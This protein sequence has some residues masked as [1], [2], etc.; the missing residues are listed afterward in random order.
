MARTTPKRSKPLIW[1]LWSYCRRNKTRNKYYC[2]KIYFYKVRNELFMYCLPTNYIYL[3]CWFC[4]SKTVTGLAAFRPT[5]DKI[6][7]IQKMPYYTKILLF[8]NTKNAFSSCCFFS[9]MPDIQRCLLFRQAWCFIYTGFT[10]WLTS[11]RIF[12]LE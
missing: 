5:A 4:V 9:G 8:N 2:M 11:I 3:N 7:L 10:V 6:Y 12:S 1:L